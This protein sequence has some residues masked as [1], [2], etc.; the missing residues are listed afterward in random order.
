MS[1]FRVTLLFWAVAVWAKTDTLLGE[2]DESGFQKCKSALNLP[3][4]EVLPGGGWDNL[5]NVDMGRVM[6]LTYSNCK[7]TEDGQYI[8][9][10]DIFTIPQKQSNLEM[11][12]EILESW[13]NYQSSTSNSINLE[14]TL[15]SKVNG[16]FS[17][18]F[19][20]MKT[21]QVKNQAIT[22]RV[23]VRNLVYTVKINPTSELSWGFRKELMDISDRLENN[24]TR[25]ATYL[26][27]LLVLNYG[28]H[29]I[30]TVDAGAA[31]IQ[32]DHIRASFL[33][34]SQSS[35]SAV[36]ASAGVT[37][38]NIINFK[39]EGNYTSQN[40][41]TKSY[42]SNRTNSLVQST[43]GVPFYPG[44]TL[45]VWQQGITNHLVAIDRAGLPLHFFVN[46]D[47]LPGLPGPLVKKL[48]KTVEAAV[49]RYY[50]FN[51]YPGCTDLNSPNFN[52]QANMDDGSC[53]GKMTNFS[54]GG[55]YQ[56]CTQLSGNEA[57]LL[58]QNLEQKNPLTGDFSCPSGYSPIHLLSQIHEEDYSHLECQRKC[59][60]LIFCKTV[61]EDVFRVAK[62]EFRAYW[63]AASGQVPENSGLLFGGL[64]SGKSIN[65]LT[66]AQS[67]PAGYFPLRLF[68]SLKVCA[69]Q[70]Y[71]LGYRF[72]VPFAGFFSCAVGNPLVDSAI[73]EDIG[74]PSLKKCPGGFS[75]HLALISDGC[76]VSYC[77]KA[78]L[79]TGGSL[80]PVRLP[81]Y[82][83]P[84]L[85]SQAATNTVMVTNTETT[86]S[87]IKDYKT[88]QWRLG[89]PLELRR[90]MKNIHGESSG[91][92]G[93]AAA[94][95]TVGV[96]TILAAVIA[97]A[98]YGSRKYK[99]REYQAIE[100]E[101]QSLAPGTA[102]AGDVP[103]K[104]P[105]Q[106]PA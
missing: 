29:V 97:L 57:I 38:L 96:T 104:E 15:F 32:E 30:T 53:E 19:Q 101:R 43:G 13:V 77:V 79:F 68:E 35:H 90:A 94:G 78:G 102:Q 7:T 65:P 12:S 14:L 60:L 59:T 48:S 72:S 17:S 11:N 22:T 73:S 63:C 9:P 34:D 83:R 5:R 31:L 93:G 42:L 99:K 61:C 41:F 100:E 58:C 87:W 44:I 3:V 80:P 105:E 66:N 45:Q 55:V 25:M 69:S 52:F 36:T 23:Q 71:E 91:L 85:M 51:T 50:M 89:E 62:A 75:Q 21:L 47:M 27:E 103:D 8:I 106:N 88:H 1:S 95:V 18:E 16:K 76:Q 33:Q 40:A 28:T 46:S 86:S 98:I 6:A 74:A 81:P 56:E 4:L 54:F 92:S 67:C 84:P 24:Q 2:T 49:R 70:D 39:F 10:D 20:R 82:T 26:A 64:F 37:F